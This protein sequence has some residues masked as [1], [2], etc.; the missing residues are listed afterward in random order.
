MQYIINSVCKEKNVS[1]L[2]QIIN[3]SNDKI[4]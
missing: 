4:K 3:T 1:I 2:Q